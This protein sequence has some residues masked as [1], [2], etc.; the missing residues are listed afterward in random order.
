MS[1]EDRVRLEPTSSHSILSTLSISLLADIHWSMSSMHRSSRSVDTASSSRQKS[2]VSC[3]STRRRRVEGRAYPPRSLGQPRTE[4]TVAGKG[5]SP[6]AL[7]TQ[8]RRRLMYQPC[9]RRGMICHGDMTWTTGVSSREDR[10]DAQAWTVAAH[11]RQCRR[12][13]SGRG[14]TELTVDHCQLLTAGR[15][16][17]S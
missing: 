13:L 12:L 14:D 11:D 15:Y 3:E 7:N 1:S 5:W 10:T 6:G 4:G 9:T 16:T 8:W 17:P 2:R